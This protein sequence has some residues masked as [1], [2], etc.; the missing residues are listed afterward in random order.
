MSKHNS[1]KRK[2][3]ALTPS[4]EVFCT[5]CANPPPIGASSNSEAYM[6]AFPGAK[7]P[8]AQL[9]L[10]K[11][12]ILRRIAEIRQENASRSR[13]EPWQVLEELAN[14]AFAKLTDYV[15]WDAAGN[16][17]TLPSSDLTEAQK[18]AIREYF[19]RDSWKG[20]RVRLHDKIAALDRLAKYL[21]LL[22]EKVDVTSAG[23]PIAALTDD[24]RADRINRL[25]DAARTRLAGRDSSSS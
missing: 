20:R 13:V 21:G 11:P 2:P 22:T 25:L 16:I 23:K 10:K 14:I 4:Q 18:S 7:T 15:R 24:E 12:K 6:R 1:D 8:K 17:E 5:L 9:L 19:G 3:T